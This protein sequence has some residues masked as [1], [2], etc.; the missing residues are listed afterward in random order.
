MA[1]WISTNFNLNKT[2]VET[3]YNCPDF[4]YAEFNLLEIPGLQDEYES[5]KPQFKLEHAILNYD[6][7]LGDESFNQLIFEYLK[8]IIR[9]VKEGF[10]SFFLLQI[11]DSDCLVEI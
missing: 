11:L 6:H 7:E 5:D 8:P 4:E 2:L 10:D 1:G 9:E 3:E